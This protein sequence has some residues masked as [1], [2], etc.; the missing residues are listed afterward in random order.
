[1]TST[2]HGIFHGD[3]DLAPPELDAGERFEPAA[4]SA[5]VGVGNSPFAAVEEGFGYVVLP[6]DPSPP[7]SPFAFAPSA[8]PAGGG[9]PVLPPI[10]TRL[11]HP[12]QAA[13]KYQ[14]AAAPP[15]AL[16]MEHF[17]ESSSAII[18]QLELRAIFGVDR[19]MDHEEILQRVR[20]L[21]GIRQVAR[22]GTQHLGALENFRQVLASLGFGT[23]GLRVYADSS[24]VEFIR[25]GNVVLAVQTDGGFAP[26]VRETLMIVAREF[27]KPV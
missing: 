27:G 1:M 20:M 26:G 23:G 6:F 12:H 21:P 8:S 7:S 15:A 25:E 16:P 17:A 22:L 14:A 13:R 24:P 11:A 4:A 10:G 2:N 19:E 18:R 9:G 5:F 3:P